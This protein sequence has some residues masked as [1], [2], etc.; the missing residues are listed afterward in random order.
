VVPDETFGQELECHESM[1][2]GVLGLVDDAD[3]AAAQ[4]LNDPVMRDAL[5]YQREDYPVRAF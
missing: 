5:A 1:E 3:T 2:L 4:F